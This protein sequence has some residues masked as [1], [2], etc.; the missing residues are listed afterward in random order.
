LRL[1]LSALFFLLT[2]AIAP[3][4]ASQPASLSI[5]NNNS[6][7]GY[8]FLFAGITQSDSME[9]QSNCSSNCA[10]PCTYGGSTVAN[11]SPT[12]LCSLSPTGVQWMA[13]ALGGAATIT[14]SAQGPAPNYEYGGTA[15]ISLSFNS[16]NGNVEAYITTDS[17]AGFALNGVTGYGSS[18]KVVNPTGY[19]FLLTFNPT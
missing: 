16:D 15:S 18:N 17:E 1:F 12:C 19:N 11:P 2:T 5:T 3:T 7:N 9:C 6:S 13:M 8:T 4:I 10:N 14:Y